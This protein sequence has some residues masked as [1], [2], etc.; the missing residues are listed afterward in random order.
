MLWFKRWCWI[1]LVLALTAVVE[2][3]T[4]T[5]DGS[6]AHPDSSQNT[7]QARKSSTDNFQLLPQ[8][9]REKYEAGFLPPGTDPENKLGWTFIK[10]LAND[11]RQFWTSPKDLAHGGA[12]TFA[13]FAALTGALIAGDSWISRQV[14]DKP[15]QLNRSLNIS[16]YSVYSLIG[17]GGGAFLWGH[18][19]NNDHLRESGLL[20][21]EAAI[22]ST[23]VTYLFKEITQRARPQVGNGNGTFF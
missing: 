1:G 4:A 23:G 16:N 12:T 7:S 5:A 15:N 18:L 20:A 19:T 11:Q 21:G 2:G 13:P 8:P 22:N 3:Q 14:P 6:E 17:V 10:H 9:A